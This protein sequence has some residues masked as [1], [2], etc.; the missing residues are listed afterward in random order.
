MTWLT[1]SGFLSGLQCHKRL[2]FEIHQPLYEAVEPS[3][4][5]LQ[6]RAFDEVVQRLRPG[7]VI[8][9]S[10]GMLSAIA[11]TQRVLAK[12]SNAPSLLYQP[13]FQAGDLAVI[14]DVLRRQDDA[15]E[16]VEVKATTQVKE[17]HL[18][19]AAFQALVLERAKIPVSRVFLGHVNNQFMLRRVGDYD[20]L[21]VEEDI[22]DMVKDYLPKAAANAAEYQGVMA[23]ATA[24][25]IDV[26]THCMEP[27]ECPF[28]AL[29]SVGRDPAPEYPVDGLPLGGKTT[30]ALLA[31]GY[32]H[33]RE[34]PAWR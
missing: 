29:C 21:L 22:T 32:R 17:T 23:S 26:G 11:E 2:C 12:G 18:P 15:F 19:D 3:I 6:G 8:S 20:G 34:V 4:P 30:A 24:P 5:I 27:Y 25:A 31:E 28:L 7:V 1:K 9:R 33:L 16:L 13:A 10:N 14:A